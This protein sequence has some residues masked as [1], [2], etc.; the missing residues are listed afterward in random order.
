V[1]VCNE[2]VAEG[3]DV[4]Q[5]RWSETRLD[6]KRF[7]HKKI[8]GTVEQYPDED[9][10][11][12]SVV[13]AGRGPCARNCT[14]AECAA[15]LTL[16]G[17]LSATLTLR[18]LPARD[19]GRTQITYSWQLLYRN[20]A[21]ASMGIRPRRFYRAEA[22]SILRSFCSLSMLSCSACMN[23]LRG[24]SS[25]ETNART[26]ETVIGTTNMASNIL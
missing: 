26:M 21:A 5:F 11:R 8:V 25:S 15:N 14:C 2:T 3:P 9:A 24:L 1:D 4:W 6:G 19:S 10:A 13:P 7:Y 17:A 23:P 16:L 20:V 12:R 22:T 18:F